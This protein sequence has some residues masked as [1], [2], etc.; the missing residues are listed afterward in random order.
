MTRILAVLY[1]AATLA[2][3]DF[4]A[5]VARIDIT[6]DG[7]IWMSGY[8]SRNHPSEGVVHQLW[9]KAL[10]IEDAKSGRLVIVTTDLVGL[11]RAVTD[12]VA[13]RVQKEYGLDRSRILLNSAHTH[14][15]PVVWPNLT[16]FILDESEE[17]KLRMYSAQL[18]EKLVDVIEKAMGDLAPAR[19]AYG[20]GTAKFAMNRRESTPRG[21]ILG[22]NPQGPVDY[23]VPVLRITSPDGT[24]RAVLF[25]YACHN[26]TLTG[27]F[28]KLSGDYAGFAEIEVERAHPGATAL[29]MMLCGGD[30]NPYPRNTLDWA[31]Q[32]GKTLAAEV[33]RVLET[34][35]DP[36]R[37][38]L[39]T[40]YQMTD[41]RFAADTR[42]VF[43]R[44]LS[45]RNPARVRRAKLMLQ[46]WDEGRPIRSVPYPV[47]GIQFGKDLTLLALGGEPVV[48]YDLRVKKE[49]GAAKIVVAGYSNDVMCYIPSLS[50][51]KAGGY[52]ADDSMVGYGQPGPFNEDVEE[53]VFAAIRQVMKRIGR[54]PLR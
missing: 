28:Y 22:V 46:L 15:G 54:A 12:V 19:I 40:A 13:A 53:T 48:D 45:N 18:T 51:L 41:L 49:F 23:D 43:E 50:V 5:G 3:A 11:P 29:F 26:T 6:P 8:A 38:P 2:G 10:A 16:M 52:E 37:P 31:E 25:A 17:R 30:Q 1:F 44:E 27:D 20:H 42:D 34:K 24:L 14:T 9:A 36:V 39:R 32:H 33:G 35:L 47:Q 7:P 21:V 4:K